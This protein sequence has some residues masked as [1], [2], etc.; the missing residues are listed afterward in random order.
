MGKPTKQQLAGMSC[1]EFK[2][3]L[4]TH[5][6]L[7]DRDFFKR[8]SMAQR[9][10]RLYRFRWWGTPTTNDFTFVVDISCSVVEFDRWANSV[11]RTIT[12]FE[13]SQE[14]KK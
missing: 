3:L 14:N 11:E 12:F 13:W 7:V 5:G 1:S 9:G 2:T 8:G 10:G 6:Y 4:K